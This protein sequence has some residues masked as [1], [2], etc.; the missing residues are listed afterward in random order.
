MG[1]GDERRIASFRV[2]RWWAVLIVVV[3]LL[4]LVALVL[5]GSWRVEVAC[6]RARAPAECVITQASI[7]LADDEQRIAVERIARA[8][9]GISVTRRSGNNPGHT[10]TS[11]VLDLTD[12]SLI[13]LSDNGL[14][15]IDPSLTAEDV[16]RL[17]RFLGDPRARTA[18]VAFGGAATAVVTGVVLA[19]F[20]A[21][22]FAMWG[23][24]TLIAAVRGG[25]TLVLTA[26]DDWTSHRLEGYAG[27][28]VDAAH[29]RL[30]VRYASGE[31]VQGP[32]VAVSAA[33]LERWAAAI[34]ARVRA[35][36]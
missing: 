14:A 15:F 27:I 31:T 26:A 1:G 24:E 9:M 2:P 10:D 29:R 8:R 25:D 22:L 7:A 21:F 19:L 30:R 34:D 17:N 5:F 12:G 11:L 23:F 33:R 16:D 32:R 3:A 13:A 36:T 4:G 18:D 28:V 6:T 20:A 35:M